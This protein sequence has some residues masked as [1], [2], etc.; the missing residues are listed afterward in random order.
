MD[1]EEE[2]G[3]WQMELGKEGSGRWSWERKGVVDGPG[4]RGRG[5]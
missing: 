1:L 2:G 4:G 3:R 5:W